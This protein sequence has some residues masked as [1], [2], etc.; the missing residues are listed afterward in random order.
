MPL[1]PVCQRDTPPASMVH[2]PYLHGPAFD[3]A[4]T[5]NPDWQRED[6]QWHHVNPDMQRWR[7]NQIVERVGDEALA[8]GYDCW[9]LFDA[10]EVMVAQGKVGAQT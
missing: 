1:C 9:V 7:Q 10:D 8:A 2:K 6:S 5:I 3:L 4:R